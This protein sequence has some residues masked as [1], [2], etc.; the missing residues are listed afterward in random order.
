MYSQAEYVCQYIV[1]AKRPEWMNRKQ[2]PL[3]KEGKEHT[4]FSN[5]SKQNKARLNSQLPLMIS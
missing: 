3:Q 2:F 4:F 1:A 5:K